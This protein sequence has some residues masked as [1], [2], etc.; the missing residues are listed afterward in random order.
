MSAAVEAALAEVD[1]AI[2]ASLVAVRTLDEAVCALAAQH[3]RE[4]ARAAAKLAR[5]EGVA[6]GLGQ[7]REKLVE[8]AKLGTAVADGTDD[9]FGS[10]TVCA[11]D[12]AH[13]EDSEEAR[14]CPV[15]AWRAAI[16]DLPEAS[17]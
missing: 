3:A 4:A 8:L 1:E 14:G 5:A 2:T 17:R 6:S 12:S 15:V 16:A 10:C 13:E 9:H 7:A 11:G